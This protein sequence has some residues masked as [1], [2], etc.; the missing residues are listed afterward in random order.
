MAMR[1]ITEQMNG[2]RECWRNLWNVHFSKRENFGR[3]LDAFEQIRELLFDALVVS[4][5]SYEGEAEG[6]DI[7]A[8][9]L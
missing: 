7:P 6:K 8:P 3:S 2:Y 4:G 5:P 9:A 1:D